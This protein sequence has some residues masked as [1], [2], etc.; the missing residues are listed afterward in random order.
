MSTIEGLDEKIQELFPLG[1]GV[2]ERMA[3]TLWGNLVYP[4]G[5]AKTQIFQGRT[6][7]VGDQRREGIIVWVGL[8]MVTSEVPLHDDMFDNN[9]Q[10]R[11][12]AAISLG[13][14]KLKRADMDVVVN[15]LDGFP[16]EV[17]PFALAK[18]EKLP[19]GFFGGIYMLS[20]RFILL[21]ERQPTLD[22]IIPT[23]F[24]QLEVLPVATFAKKLEL[25]LSPLWSTRLFTESQP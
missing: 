2:I 24:R 21:A 12:K 10:R 25:G 20:N 13:N 22:V 4:V 19:D 9:D 16:Q 15:H 7:K 14:L 11:I 1:S 17:E 6:V 5:L 3:Q 23:R 8:S 18:R